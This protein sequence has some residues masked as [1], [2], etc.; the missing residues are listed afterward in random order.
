MGAAPEALLGPKRPDRI[1]A[2]RLA[3]GHPTGRE[4]DDAQL[5]QRGSD[6]RGVARRDAEQLPGETA[7]RRELPNQNPV[8]V[9]VYV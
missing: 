9:Q 4:R 2:A 7:A 3:R 1:D 8:G 6:R 5:R